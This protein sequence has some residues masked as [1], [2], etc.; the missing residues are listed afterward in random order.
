MLATGLQIGGNGGGTFATS[1]SA[2]TA[3]GANGMVMVE[4]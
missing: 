4:W 3:V 1:N 2:T